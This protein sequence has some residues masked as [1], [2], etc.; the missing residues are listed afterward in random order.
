MKR[1]LL[2]VAVCT[3]FAATLSACATKTTSDSADPAAVSHEPVALRELLRRQ[4]SG[5]VRGP[6]AHIL[7]RD[8][9]YWAS[10]WASISDSA[11]PPID[12]RSEWVLIIAERTPGLS[13]GIE[14]DSA[15]MNGRGDLLVFATLHGPNPDCV[16]QQVYEGRATAAYAIRLRGYRTMSVSTGYRVGPPCG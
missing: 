1:Y 8:Q 12:F 15:R 6:T 9:R 13:Y 10:A 4:G 3:S 7:I 2:P 11:P 16:Q 14:A 5:A